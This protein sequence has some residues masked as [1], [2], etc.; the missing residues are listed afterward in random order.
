MT[1]KDLT[2]DQV[3]GG[4]KSDSILLIDVR[5]PAE[6]AAARIQGAVLFPLSAFDPR[7]LP[8]CGERKLVFH[9]ASSI[10]SAQA[11]AVCR[12]AGLPHDSHLKGGI[13]A[14]RTAG[15]PVVATGP[16]TGK[17]RNRS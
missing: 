5:E 10:R 7:A 8:D 6:Y 15:L 17:P 12:R 3:A 13:Q 1:A 14:W 4:L 9:C 2:A 11:V 16:L